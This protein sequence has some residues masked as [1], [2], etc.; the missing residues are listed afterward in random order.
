MQ[1]T[2]TPIVLAM[3]CLNFIAKAQEPIPKSQ[4]QKFIAITGKI[5]DEKGLPIPGTTV[6]VKQEKQYVIANTD[7]TFA[8]KQ[9]AKGSTITITSIGYQT[10]EIANIQNSNLGNIVLA[11]N[12]NQLK[13]IEINAG[14]Y[15]VKDRERTG[16]ISRV[17]SETI[18]KQ[19]VNNVLGALIGR[20]PG[21]NIEQQS[22]INGGGYKV[23]IR[24]VNS[25]RTDGR[26]PLY[27]VDGVPY[28]SSSLTDPNMGTSNVSGIGS[29]LNYLSPSDIASIE[30]LKD[31]DATAI[32]GSRGANG[33][34]LITT[35]KARAHHTSLD[36]NVSSGISRVGTKLKLLNT[37]QYLEMRN[38]AFKNDGVSPGIADYDANGTWDQKRYTDWQKVLLGGTARTTNVQTNLTGGNEWTQF[39]FR[40]NYS[41]QTTVYPGSFSDQKG[42]GTLTVNHTSADKKFTADFSSTY[43]IEKND[44]PQTDLASFITLAPNAPPLYDTNGNLNWAL[45]GNGGATWNNP[46]AALGNT[47]TGKSNA[48]ISS[49]M[50]NYKVL[51]GLT[52][53]SNVGYTNIRLRENTLSPIGA[54]MPSPYATGT[55]YLSF[56]TQQTW[57]IEPQITYQKELEGGTLNL[58]LGSTFQKDNQQNESLVGFGYTDDLLLGSITA[59]P[60]KSGLAT[61]S[62]YQYNALFARINYNYRGK[63]LINLTGRRDGSSRFGPGKQFANFGAMGLGWIFTDENLFKHLSDGVFS[64]GK[65][66]ASY[67]VTGS[68]QIANFGYL[69]TYLASQSY[70]D[71][72]ALFPN[73]LAN[74]DYSWE[75][76]KKLE[77]ALDLGFMED[78]ILLN[79]SWY[80]N[81]SS[82]Q[83]VGY[84]LP[85]ITGFSSV[86]YNLPATVQNTGWE[87]ELN[88]ANISRKSFSWKSALTLTI[89]KNKLLAFPNLKGSTYVNTYAV[90]SS[91]YSPIGYHYIGVNPQTGVYTYADLNGNG[92]D[93]DQADKRVAEKALTTSLYGGLQNSFTFKNFQLDVFLQF[94]SKT[95]RNPLF[96]FNA[97]G[98]MGNQLVEVM[99]R[100]QKTGDLSDVQRFTQS[101]DGAGGAGQR[102]DDLVQSDRF[103]D[104]SFVRIKNVSLSWTAPENW[105]RQAKLHHFKVYIQGQNLF[106]FTKYPGDPETVNLRALPS[107]TTITAGMQIGF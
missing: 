17:T 75:T 18:D 92:N 21:V 26:Q 39:A 82:N 29:P 104:L 70:L 14:Y 107:L 101:Y 61:N 44:L 77:A 49:A 41:K 95:V 99:G 25:L 88:T 105:I 66:R 85:D 8:L 93:T 53:K 47:Y 90:G 55:N 45:D 58:L 42:S 64:F 50:L 78:K 22:G 9:A 2:I 40:G 73:R 74:P 4:P 62:E 12:N 30:V 31:A 84:P 48:F 23:E 67:G 11:I 38:E 60:Q 57:I 1:K 15:T 35:K 5:I 59:A 19:P 65:L 34:V 54:Q 98:T 83:L 94:A 51:P 106:T 100:W 6:T 32:Y 24:G 89:P 16:S 13:E 52:L 79:V 87:F 80:Q 3:L 7:G 102:F 56:N 69:N 97:A 103:T 27:L 71:G 63:Y 81:R 91:L 33:V 20:M 10:K 86:Q 72:A 68:D 46:V 37:P 28:P 76:N 43:A 36:V 96:F